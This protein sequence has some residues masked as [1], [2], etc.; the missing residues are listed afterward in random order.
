VAEE[1]AFLYRTWGVDYFFIVDSVFNLDRERELALAEEIGRRSLPIRWGAFFLPAGIDAGYLGALQASGLTHVEFGTDALCAPMLASYAKGFGVADVLEAYRTCREVGVHQA[2]YL[3]FGGPGETEATVTETVDRARALE[4][5]VF[6]PFVGLR[7]YPGT[8][9]FE[10][11]REEGLVSSAGGCLEAVFY[12]SAAVGA[13][14]AWA[15]VARAAAGERR[16]V[17]PSSYEAM[18]AITAR[19]R[20]RG[21]KGPLWEY[22]IDRA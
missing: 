2:H 3:L 19:L 8:R 16:W 5:C 10:S 12:I 22:L 11:A 20:K 7:V 13:E 4:G 9:L 1:M 14:Q 15:I 18:A 6:F 21:R 17:L